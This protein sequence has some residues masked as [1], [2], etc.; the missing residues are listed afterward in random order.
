M[1]YMDKLS[2]TQ[3]KELYSLQKKAVRLIFN[4][5]KNVHTEKLFKLTNIVPITKPYESECCKFV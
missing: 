3:M 1:T 5:R 2:K 4:A